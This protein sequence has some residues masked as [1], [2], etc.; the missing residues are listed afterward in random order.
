MLSLSEVTGLAPVADR[1]PLPRRQWFYVAAAYL[2]AQDVEKITKLEN[3]P[4]VTPVEGVQMVDLHS[5][6]ERVGTYR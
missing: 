4:L 2:M 3:A 5:A 1:P 6:T